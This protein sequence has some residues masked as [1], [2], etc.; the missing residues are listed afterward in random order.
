MKKLNKNCLS[1]G[2]KKLLF[3]ALPML[4]ILS[5]ILINDSAFAWNRL[6]DVQVGPGRPDA[7]KVS[8]KRFN[9]GRE[10]ITIS[11]NSYSIWEYRHLRQTYRTFTFPGNGFEGEVG[12]PWT[13]VFSKIFKAAPGEKIIFED[14]QYEW[15][16]KEAYARWFPQQ[17]PRSDLDALKKLKKNEKTYARKGDIF[18]GIRVTLSSPKKIW[19][20]SYIAMFLR[21]FKYFPLEGKVGFLKEAKITL[22]RLNSPSRKPGNVE[23]KV[24]KHSDYII[25]TP[26]RFLKTLQP[27]INFK[28]KQHPDL[29][30]KTLEEI[31][32]SVAK[33]DREIEK[34]GSRGTKFFLLVG[35]SSVLPAKAYKSPWNDTGKPDCFDADYVYRNH[36]K[37]EFPSYKVGRFPAVTESELETI[38]AKTLRRWQK[39]GSYQTHPMLIAHEEEAPGKY[40]G[41][42]TD[43]YEY[44]IPS[45]KT[46]LSP[47]MILPAAKSNGGLNSR[48]EDFYK[49]L[50]SG[51]GVM[52]YRGHGGSDFLATKLLGYWGLRQS[53]W[54]EAE[55]SVPLVFYS[56]A[57]LNGQMTDEKGKRINGLCEN[58]LNSKAYGVAGAIGAIQP[59]PTTPNHTFA[60]N[61]MYYTYVQPKRTL[62]DVFQISLLESMKYGF[63]NNINAQSW[64]WLGDLY[65]LYGDPELPVTNLK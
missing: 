50:Q 56:I 34:A 36:G 25:I 19:G 38:I 2:L 58:L 18:D 20:Q 65:N 48:K 23:R 44:V 45:S 52:L 21:P 41:C 59:S 57:C 46:K 32:V 16:P 54:Y 6:D 63:A 43:I 37:D 4:L 5:F 31:G 24:K 62:G 29:V 17:E 13:P 40:Q 1:G 30:I 9:D 39:P 49:A 15:S 64:N 12:D 53:D 35:H 10:V 28:R 22:R 7:P 8:S 55:S 3:S 47:R 27:F 61:L 42:V 11:F 60:Y 51:V 33:I 26:E 14:A